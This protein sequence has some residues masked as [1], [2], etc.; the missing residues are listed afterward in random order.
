[1]TLYFDGAVI[2]APYNAATLSG[3]TA[4]LPGLPLSIHLVT[5]DAWNMFGAVTISANFTIDDPII[6][7][8]STASAVE[9]VS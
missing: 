6:D 1:M 5:V 7:P 4:L 2:A 8:S 3:S 9:T